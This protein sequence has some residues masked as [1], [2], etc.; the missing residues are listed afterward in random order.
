MKYTKTVVSA[1][2]RLPARH[3]TTRQNKL[4]RPW[5]THTNAD[6]VA[7]YKSSQSIDSMMISTNPVQKKQQPQKILANT[8]TKGRIHKD[9]ETD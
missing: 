9:A 7:T 2:C 3:V 8:A 1:K 6:A 5:E 4:E